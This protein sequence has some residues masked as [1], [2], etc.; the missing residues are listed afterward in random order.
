M[1]MEYAIERREQIAERLRL[2]SQDSIGNLAAEFGVSRYTIMRDLLV[3]SLSYPIETVKGVGGG[4]FW[5]GTRNND[6]YTARELEALHN[7]ALTASPEDKLVIERLIAAHT[8]GK[9][10][11]VVVDQI[12]Q[13]L[14]SGISQNSLADK[15]GISKG[16]LSKIVCGRRKPSVALAQRIKDLLKETSDESREME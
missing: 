6:T 15:L 2:R 8:P 7:A 9:E 14:R 1:A 11:P 12:F 5:R 4:V 13:I 10:K 16:Q 3:L